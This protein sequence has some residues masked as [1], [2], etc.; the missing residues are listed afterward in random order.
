MAH[1]R[2]YFRILSDRID[3]KNRMYSADIAGIVI[4]VGVQVTKFA[5]RGRVVVLAP[6]HFAGIEK[7]PE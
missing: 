2:T 3:M 4:M 1:I 7:V 5:P 6:N